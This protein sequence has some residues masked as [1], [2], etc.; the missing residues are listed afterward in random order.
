M[1]D[2]LAND[3]TVVVEAWLDEAAADVLET[4]IEEGELPGALITSGPLLAAADHA[5]VDVLDARTL[6]LLEEIPTDE[7]VRA[8]MLADPDGDEPTLYAAAGDELVH[9]RITDEGLGTPE[10]MWMPGVI[11]DLAW[12]A[13]A[14]LFHALGEAPSGG[15]T[16]YVV[17]PRGRA[18]FIDVPLPFEPERIL[19]DTLPDHPSA[20]RTELLALAPDGELAAVEIGRNGF[21]WRLPGVLLGAL[22]AALMYLLARVLFARRSVG[23][24]AAVL[25][26][27][28]GM[29]LANARIGMNDVYVTTFVVMAALLFAPLYLA[30]R[31]PWTAVALLLG[32]GVALGL[33]LASKW[34]ALYA[35]GGLGLLV[36][37]R[38]AL[39]RAIA[40]LVMVGLTTVLGAM[41]IRT[42]PVDEPMRN[43]IF[44]VLMLL[45]TGL[46]AA[47]VVRRP[48]PFT[49]AEVVLA[50]AAPVAAGVGLALLGKLEYSGYAF[51]AAAGVAV[52]AMI[53]TSTGHG[54]W[55]PGARP[56]TPGTSVWLR[57]GP[58]QVV[59]WLLTLGALTALPLIVYLVG[60]APWVDLGNAWGL[61]LF[62]DLPGLPASTEGGRTI[63]DLTESMYWY[64]DSLR[65]E[66][67]ASSPWWAWALDLKPVWFFQERYAGGATGLIYDTGNLVIFWLGI[68]GMGFS[69][70]MAWRRRSLALTLVVLMWA[71]MW[72][73]W[74]RVDRAAFQYHVY[75]SVPFMITALAYFLAELWHGPSARTW[76]LARASAALAILAVP[77][78]WLLRT[79]LCVLSG[80]AVAHPDGVACA[81]E[82]TRTAQLTEGG[83]TALLVLGVGAGVAAFLAWRAA[84]SPGAR[85]QSI[86]VAGLVLVGLL[87]LGGVVGALLL[88]DT[89]TTTG[90][91]LS[92]DVLAL[93]GLLVLAVPAWLTLRAR[94]PRRLVLG[95][96]G[97][98]LIWLVVW[99]PNIAGLPLPPDL[100]HIYQG[101][102]PTWNWDFQFA[103]NTDPAIDG[104]AID[105]G[106]LIVG[107]LTVVFVAAVAYAAWR[108][109]RSPAGLAEGPPSVR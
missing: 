88:L 36:L 45:L 29:L 93:A 57:P 71:A 90:L 76:F 15:P 21:G 86:Y 64:H 25:I 7:P 32:V 30:P 10:T 104:G 109:G 99:Y 41:A 3:G 59:P 65:A 73:P 108:W 46:L 62:G 81:S 27:A 34:V 17:E 89:A 74:A 48:I 53:A 85:S 68:A 103:V 2:R 52:L 33:G 101:L 70:F 13:S 4:A 54:P 105:Q 96:L 107:V 78:S 39:G 47:A 35:I 31:R 91:T 58:V 5:G 97:A 38:S 49:R 42:A 6:K 94:D 60:Y 19:A 77:L 56:P 8:L 11:T 75:A 9:V 51:A 83:V 24:I 14:G 79:P 50:A 26:V 43:W 1:A 87:T 23:L 95:V 18:V 80:T 37:L 92:S 28:E 102:L 40:L 22:T 82:V 63:A 100:A 69:A 16:A 67:A 106:T 61:P 20:D 44:L 12:N 55:A 66:H 72:L 84:G 98:A